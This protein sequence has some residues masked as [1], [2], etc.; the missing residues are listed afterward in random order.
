MNISN[1]FRA[2]AVHYSENVINFARKLTFL[3][4]FL[5]AGNAHVLKAKPQAVMIKLTYICFAML[6]FDFSILFL[7]LFFVSNKVHKVLYIET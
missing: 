6:Y 4:F 7:F 2:R 5:Y 1:Q 3:L